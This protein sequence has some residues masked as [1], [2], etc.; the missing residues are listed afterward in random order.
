[1]NR[2]KIHRQAAQPC[3]D[4][5]TIKPIAELVD[6]YKK[7][8]SFDPFARNSTIADVRNDLDPETK[9]NHHMVAEQF[10]AGLEEEAF[11]FAIFD[12]PYS[13]RQTK[14]LYDSIGMKLTQEKTQ[15]RQWSDWGNGIGKAL[16][17]GG[18]CVKCG[19]NSC[20]P[21]EGASLIEMLA[22]CHGGMHNDTIVTVW[23]KTYH[24]KELFTL[25]P[26]H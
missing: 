11:A 21:F 9:A 8:P 3:G 20:R 10:L 14:E 15:S 24:Q 12:P 22:V 16:K 26:S 4:T 6:S 2:Y 17:V 23:E 13:P 18:I 1:M 19:W 25:L 5:L 7:S